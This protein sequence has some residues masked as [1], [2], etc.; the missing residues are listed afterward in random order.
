M[1]SFQLRDKALKDIYKHED[2]KDLNIKFSDGEV[3]KVHSFMLM[4]MSPVF[5]RML[6]VNMKEKVNNTIEIREDKKET[7]LSM[8]E[9]L[10]V[11]ELNTNA[12]DLEDLLKLSDKYQI[13]FLHQTISNYLEEH[14]TDGNA[15]D[16]LILAKTYNS[17]R[18]YETSVQYVLDN[19]S[20]ALGEHWDEKLIHFPEI[21]IKILRKLNEN[22]SKFHEYNGL[23]DSLAIQGY[24]NGGR[25]SIKFV[26]NDN[27]RLVG[28]GLYGHAKQG[29]MYRAKIS[30]QEE[31]SGIIFEGEREY[32]SIKNQKVILVRLDQET[33]IKIRKN[34]SYEIEAIISGSNYFHFENFNLNQDLHNADTTMV[35]SISSSNQF[36]DDEVPALFFSR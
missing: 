24:R 7:F 1:T 8:V 28:I 33:K 4:S 12:C 2:S 36:N 16:F 29:L 3:I 11:A 27:C 14:I 31:N 20:S 19:V 6:N 26:T 21:A 17:D 9:F 10:Y 15:I 23:S 22:A 32:Q 30:V 25:A 18:L 13:Q 34:R 5:D 35:V